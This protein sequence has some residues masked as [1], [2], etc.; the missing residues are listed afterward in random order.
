MSKNPDMIVYSVRR[1]EEKKPY[2][3]RVG[4]AWASK[5]GYTIEL[6]A[7]PIDGRL[8]LL[9]PKADEPGEPAEDQSA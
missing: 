8:V 1:R 9:Q 6:D 3:M 7:F 5:G 2:W 4:A